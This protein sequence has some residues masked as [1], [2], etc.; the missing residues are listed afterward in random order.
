MR[1]NKTIS[2]AIL[3]LA[4]TAT[5]AAWGQVERGGITGKVTDSTGAILGAATVTIKNED[6]G[7]TSTAKTNDSGDFLFTDLNPGK[8]TVVVTMPGFQKVETDHVQVDVGS[9]VKNDAQLPVGT[10]EQSVTVQA[11]AQQLNYNSGGLG[12]VIEQKAITDLP[13]IYGNPFALEF[14]APGITISGVN[15]NIHVYDSSSATVSV[16]GSALNA[17]DYKLDGAPDNRVRFSAFTPSTEFISQY[18]LD[19]STYDAS[20]GHSSGG[21]VNTQ[22]KSGTN[23]IHGSVF[24]YYQNPKINA[25]TWV[26]S[27]TA[28][29]AK[30]TFVREGADAGGPL[31]KDRAFWF[32]GYEH[33]RQG[34]P[35]PQTLTVPTVA[36]RNGD[37]SA[38]LGLGT[39]TTC[40][41]GATPTAIP[42]G[43]NPYQI[44]SPYTAIPTTTTATT[45]N[46]LCIPGNI[47]P[48][49]QINPIAAADLAMYPLPNA[50]GKAD[51]ENNFFYAGVEPDNYN[52]EILRLDGTISQRQNAYLHLIRSSRVQL[53]KNNYFPPI[54]GTTLD[55]EN[56]GVALGHV[57][58]VNPNIVATTV[59]SYTRFTTQS[60]PGALNTITPTSE[61]FP[62]Y[63]TTNQNMFA[64]SAPRIDLT[65]YTSA[66]TASGVQS[67]DD[68]YLGSFSLSQ[69]KGPFFLRYGMEYRRYLTN[70]LS[71][72]TEQGQYGSTGSLTSATSSVTPATGIGLAVAQLELGALS[73]GSQN[74]NSD[75]AI[76]SDYYAGYFQNDW[77]AT[78]KLTLNMG[79]RWEYE[80][81]DVERNNKQAVAFNFNAANSTTTAAAT[82]FASKVAGT[83]ALLPSSISPTG[84]LVF[85]GV[86]GAGKNPYN[87]PIYD[88]LPRVGFAYAALPNTVLRG[89]F[90]IF[91]DSLNSEY[92]SGGNNGSTTTF[93]IPQQGFSATSSVSAPTFT[94]NGNGTG[95]LN[96][97]STLSNP[98]PSGLTPITGN[99]LGTSTALGQ[100]VQFLLPNPHTP[101][102]E[103]FSVGIQHQFGQWVGS[104]DYVGNHGVHQPVQ[105]ITQG[106]NTGGEE[107]NNVPAQYY[108]K[109]A[110]GYDYTENTAI[111]NT[112]SVVNPFYGLIP[113]GAVNNLS[114]S[115]LTV[116]Q[117][118]R[119]RPEFASINALSFNGNSIY[120]SLQGEL[121]RRFS[122][123]LEFTAAYTW[124]RTLDATTYL[125]PTD[126]AP[127]YGV[128]ANDRPQRLAMSG[129]YEL[130]FGRGRRFFANSNKIVA[131]VIGGWQMQG[132]YQIQSGAPITFTTNPTFLANNGGDAH[133][134]RSQYKQSIATNGTGTGN[135][136]NTA[137]F[138]SINGTKGTPDYLLSCGT[139]AY[140]A[141][142]LPGTYQIRTFPLRFNTLRADNLNQ[143]DAGVQRE[144]K[145]WELGTLQFRGEAINLLNHP[146]Y[147][148]PAVNPSTATFGQIVSQANQPRVYQFAGF[149]R[150]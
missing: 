23:R 40:A 41:A 16:N 73:S 146:V 44:F 13:L 32:A 7:V 3:A 126:T 98:F 107:F 140:C 39:G 22:L 82:T 55:Y 97:T 57:F 85:A 110:N 15:P 135:W 67:F 92:L 106:T 8:Y 58:I 108:S 91:F 87:S 26:D 76:R 100:N 122:N 117:L 42:T 53:N 84:G 12:M 147:S 43:A 66:T 17:L 127:W 45:Y 10:T 121:Q 60:L 30:P 89:G 133:F 64:N 143:F 132:V 61:G 120:N 18:K 130:P 68:I 94:N 102:N 34:T 112:S 116:A 48:K 51:G 5:S 54:S 69:T 136:F 105:Q 134:T 75:F 145:L 124:S 20:Q 148:A 70:G 46:R 37:F 81:P 78:S 113:S 109:I 72:T 4:M 95:T 63:T 131:Q 77:R 99:S 90:G 141:T 65:T 123:G 11:G 139:A 125:N 62:A 52:A 47:I 129:I 111:N 115:K 88:F 2:C 19:T 101:Y 79:L 56:R 49:S 29:Q 138:V 25:N 74:Q 9:R 150:F 31:W 80:T 137:D 71:G 21:F 27:P 103:R 14:L 59:L 38:L 114:S 1:F 50:V 119:P 24:A 28:Q 35:N 104:I 144:F 128:S 33:S 149:F 142:Q 93:L 6:T 36:E 83:N 86:N 118:L 96:Y